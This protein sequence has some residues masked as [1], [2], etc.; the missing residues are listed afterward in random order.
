[1]ETHAYGAG[2]Q[3][4]TR[5]PVITVSSEPGS[6]GTI[7]AQEVAKRLD[8]DYFH[9]DIVEGIAKSAVIV[10]RGANFILPPEERISIRVIAPLDKRVRNVADW[11]NTS[12]EKTRQRSYE[13][14]P[15]PKT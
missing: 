1:M 7:V 13:Q 14:H 5:L 2:P 3:K 8:F 10:G 11:H 4:K 9:R 15:T 12:L 6:S